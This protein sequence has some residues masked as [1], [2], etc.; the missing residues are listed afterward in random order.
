MTRQTI[1]A[2]TSAVVTVKLT[3]KGRQLRRAGRDVRVKAAFTAKGA[4]SPKTA[5]STKPKRR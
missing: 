5:Y 3:G 2:A 4:K 1:G